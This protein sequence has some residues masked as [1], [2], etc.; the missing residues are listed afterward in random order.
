MLGVVLLSEYNEIVHAFGNSTFRQHFFAGHTYSEGNGQLSS[1]SGVSSSAS[2]NSPM[3]Q[4][5]EDKM[6][7]PNANY[8]EEVSKLQKHKFNF[9]NF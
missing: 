6:M 5:K 7:A 3:E 2:S 8:E 9:M 4:I 1:S